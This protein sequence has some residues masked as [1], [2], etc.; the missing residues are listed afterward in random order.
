MIFVQKPGKSLET[1]EDISVSLIFYFPD[2]KIVNI[3]HAKKRNNENT[4]S[5]CMKSPNMF[6]KTVRLIFGS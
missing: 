4:T 6:L 3:I 5:L 2:L 1:A